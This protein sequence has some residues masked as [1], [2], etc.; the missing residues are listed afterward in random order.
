MTHP[1]HSLRIRVLD[2]QVKLL[3]LNVCKDAKVVVERGAGRDGDMPAVALH[4]NVDDPLHIQRNQSN[5]VHLVDEM[6]DF[7][8]H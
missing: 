3:L 2:I 4:N 7:V 1:L 6:A 8:A 5:A